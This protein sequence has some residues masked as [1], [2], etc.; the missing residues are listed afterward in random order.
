MNSSDNAL[1]VNPLPISESVPSDSKQMQSFLDYQFRRIAN[2]VNGKESALYLLQELGCFK[3]YFTSSDPL[4]FRNVYRF[5][6]D[7]VAK[8]RALEP[9]DPTRNLLPATTYTFAHGITGINSPTLILGTGTTTEA[10]PRFIPIPFVPTGTA[11]TNPQESI[12]LHATG[13]NIVVTM[14]PDAP[15][16]S[17]CYVLFEYTKN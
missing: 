6:M 2:S 1:I 16:L 17:Q 3:S 8:Q 9:P 14:G 7:V 5:N 12:Q 4:K 10:T 13:T 15:T 11:S